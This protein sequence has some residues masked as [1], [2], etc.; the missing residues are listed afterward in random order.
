[1]VEMIAGNPHGAIA[2]LRAAY[3]GLGTLG[4]GADA[5][6]AAALLATALLAEGEV[7][8]A[9]LMAAESEALAGQNLKTAIGWRVAR[10]EV[11][12]ARGDLTRAVALAEEAVG[13]A[14]GTDLVID[15]ADACVAL[16]TLRS[17][18]GDAA[19]R[20][21]SARR[22]EAPL[23][24][25][26]CD[27]P[28][29]AVGRGGSPGCGTA[30]RRSG[31][32]GRADAGRAG[33]SPPIENAA[34]RGFARV[35]T[36]ATSDRFDEFGS[37]VAFD[38]ER[39]DRRTGVSADPVQG[40]EAWATAFRSTIEIGMDHLAVE[41]V[42][43]RGERLALV[44]L[45]FTTEGGDEV[46]M[47]AV[48]EVDTSGRLCFAAWHDADALTA[49]VEELDARYVAGEGAEHA[50]V[51]AMNAASFR[52]LN[53]HDHDAFRELVAPGWVW[54]DHR[55]LSTPTLDL[56]GFIEWQEG[57]ADVQSVAIVVD[58][59]VRDH[60]S[61]ATALNHALDANGGEI[62][63][64]FHIVSAAGPDGRFVRAD[65]FDGDQWDAALARFEE[66]RSAAP[67]RP[68]VENT[69]SRVDARVVELLSAGS[70][71]ELGELVA[72]GFVFE[73]RRH[74]VNFGVSDLATSASHL[75]WARRD[76][77]VVAIPE[78]VAVRGDRLVLS[79]RS[80]SAPTGHTRASFA[81]VEVD[82][83]DRLITL[84]QFDEG[85]LAAAVEELDA[86]YVAGEGAEDAAVL[87]ALA[88]W[89][90][91]VNDFDFD[92]MRSLVTD[93]FTW[94]D[95]LQLGW[96]VLDVEGFLDQRRQ[97]LDLLSFAVNTQIRVHGGVVLSVTHSRADGPDGRR[98]EWDFAVV[99][100]WR[101]DGRL[102]RAESFDLDHWDAALARFDELSNGVASGPTIENAST[103]ANIRWWQAAME[104]QFDEVRESLRSDYRGE[105]RRQIVAGPLTTDRDEAV[106][107]MR[108]YLDLGVVSARVEPLAVRGKCLSLHRLVLG[109]DRGDEVTGL[110]VTEHTVD[111][112]GVAAVA[113]DEDDLEAAVEELDRRYLAGEGAEHPL[114]VQLVSACDAAASNRSDFEEFRNIAHPGF[115]LVDRRQ[116]GWTELS[117]DEFIAFSRQYDDMRVSY[118]TTT[119][120]IANGVSLSSQVNHA[121]DTE[122]GDFEWRLVVVGLLGPDGTA[123]RVEI[124]DEADWDAAL[125][126]FDELASEPVDPRKPNV[127]NAVTRSRIAWAAIIRNGRFDEARARMGEFVS[128]DGV[129]R[130]D[131]RRTV[132]A[133]EADGP[134]IADSLQALYE[135]GLVEVAVDPS[136][137]GLSALPCTARCSAAPVAMS[138]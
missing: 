122:G 8:E 42:A 112:L 95:H 9:E 19:S 72:P 54:E 20:A 53:T 4:V 3:Q 131:R 49:A 83:R 33:G 123:E 56:D 40:P 118:L 103:R 104:R 12:A 90:R 13:I 37:V 73:D 62:V 134:G 133:P 1:M 25:E 71:H 101:T 92:A 85:D 66:L 124:F 100:V 29:H 52:A 60:V 14:A 67:R 22:R 129:Q 89:T 109:T 88:A 137:S 79:R 61:L 128:D 18:A 59:T 46:P 51:V 126:R 127:E 94:V 96:G 116:M 125:A 6:Q 30:P 81:V 32:R 35:A 78:V 74:V 36:L 43:I 23:R 58:I 65:A 39:I 70:D 136:R 48:I 121:T 97:Y 10:A 110:M 114:E 34:T 82:D 64:S 28:R 16:A 2:P 84:V 41:P 135:L 77:F 50:E 45:T 106:A 11:L 117:L 130:I 44:R 138:S 98:A 113:F 80:Q 99:A 63:W 107:S 91:A 132:A 26:G 75:E 31:G 7:D 68:R 120:R 105:D 119:L 24:A 5:G 87:A 111:G 15:H 21:R 76:G 38:F 27:G 115:T 47:L 69:A 93:D 17:R 102:Q 86:R 55:A 57:Y 108:A